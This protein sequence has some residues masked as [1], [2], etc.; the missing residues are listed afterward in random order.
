MPAWSHTGTPA[1][2]PGFGHLTVSA[3]SGSAAW[4]SARSFA[5][6]SPRQSPS[7]AIFASIS[8]A[9]IASSS[10]LLAGQRRGLFHPAGERRLV[11]LVVLLDMEIARVAAFR[12]DRRHRIAR[13][14]GKEELGR[15]AG[16]GRGWPYG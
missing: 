12:S 16:R 3:T 13:L 8:S 15:A 1:G 2:L 14:A 9:A 10:H 4:I 5:S 11:D 7:P 6:V